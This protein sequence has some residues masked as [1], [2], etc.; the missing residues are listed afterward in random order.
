[1]PLVER[2]GVVHLAP[3]Q[4]AKGYRF[5]EYQVREPDYQ[6]FLSAK[7]LYHWRKEGRFQQK[8]MTTIPAP[9]A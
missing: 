5:V 4:Y 2:Y 8:D 7:D 1:M 3:T 6:A 9:A